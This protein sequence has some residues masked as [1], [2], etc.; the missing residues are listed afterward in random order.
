[1]NL[2]ARLG[3]ARVGIELRQFFRDRES[4]AFNF[5]LPMVLLVVF[6][7]AFGDATLGTTDITFAQYFFAGMIASGILY[8][9]FQN[10]AIAIPMER[11][12]GT[13]KRLQGTPMPSASYF[14]GKIGMVFVAYV[15]QVVI[16]LLVGVLL[17]DIDLPSSADRWFTFVWVSV[18]G[19]IGAT[20]LGIAYSVVPRSGRGASAMV[21]PVVLVLQFISGVFF[22]FPDLPTWMQ[23]LASIFPLKWL[24]QA[25]R[26]VFLP[27]SAESLEVGG[28][29]N[30]GMCAFMLVLWAVIG[31]VLAVKLFRWTPRGTR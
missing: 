18:L 23:R 1:V 3:A 28:S 17:Y 10:L 7:S 9:S 31:F 11:D 30:L 16:L 19:L 4:A 12:D 2:T 14:V 13:L 21:A 15:A 29:W 8:T 6:G 20:L 27:D 25:M 26:Y 5:A 24:T 22:Y